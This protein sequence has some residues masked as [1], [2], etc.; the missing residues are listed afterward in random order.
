[1]IQDFINELAI[2][3]WRRGVRDP[4]AIH[5]AVMAEVKRIVFAEARAKVA[6][7]SNPALRGVMAKLLEEEIAHADQ[8]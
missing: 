7:I 2:E 5:A 1:M 4:D 3:Q 6:A 8:P